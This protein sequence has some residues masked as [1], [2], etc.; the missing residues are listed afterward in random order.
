MFSRG[1]PGVGKTTVALQ[2]AKDTEMGYLEVDSLIEKEESRLGFSLSRQVPD[3]EGEH[4]IVPDPVLFSLIKQE[5]T[6]QLATGYDEI[7]IDG[8]M[9]T[10][11]AYYFLNRCFNYQSTF[12]LHADEEIRF[13]R[14]V[15]R[16]CHLDKNN[17]NEADYVRARQKFHRNAQP[18]QDA[19][20][21][22]LLD[23]GRGGI[24]KSTRLVGTRTLD[25]W[26]VAN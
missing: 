21:A 24:T 22:W 11:D 2:L 19:A 16:R 26:R 23:A 9:M 15:G 20:I 25:D 5:I 6:D 10:P 18:Y 1:A 13:S 3:G 4:K 17:L 8:L 14:W 7:I 12:M